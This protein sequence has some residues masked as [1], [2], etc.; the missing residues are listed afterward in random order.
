MKNSNK[1]M[2]KT[3]RIYFL[4]LVG[5]IAVFIIAIL[6]YIFDKN[7]FGVAQ[8]W[9]FFNEFSLVHLLWVLWMCDMVMQLIPVKSH[10]SI[11]S[12]KTAIWHLSVRNVQIS[13]VHNIAE[14]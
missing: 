7:A 6:T 10:I 11:G 13:S 12:G 14:N 5:R 3:R 1:G 2:S 4:R 9:H 8:G